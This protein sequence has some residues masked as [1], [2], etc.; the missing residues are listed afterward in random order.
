MP[1]KDLALKIEHLKKSKARGYVDR[2]IREFRELSKKGNREWFSEMC[3]CILTANSTAKLGVRIQE[4]VGNGFLTLPEEELVERLKRFG[5][6]FPNTRAKFITGARKF[7]DIKDMITARRDTRKMREWLNRHV[8]GLGWK[9]S[10][11]FLRNVGYT[12][13]AIIDRHVL[14][15]MAKY[16]LIPRVPKSLNRR[17]YLAYEEKLERV[18]EKVG[19]TLAE[20]DLYLWYMKTGYVM[21]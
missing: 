1:E 6:R 21:K 13:V 16:G 8:K 9:E 11:H 2:R 7:A 10:S 14:W 18:A 12:D 3:F 17:L 4:S 19:L 20:L 15:V 5:H